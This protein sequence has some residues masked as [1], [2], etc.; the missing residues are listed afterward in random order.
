MYRYSL[1]WEFCEHRKGDGDGRVEVGA[2]KLSAKS[3][4][5]T[6]KPKPQVMATWKSRTGASMATEVATAPHPKNTSRKVP[7]TLLGS[8]VDLSVSYFRIR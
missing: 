2:A 5:A 6:D 7:R 3:K 8:I 1:G 4:I